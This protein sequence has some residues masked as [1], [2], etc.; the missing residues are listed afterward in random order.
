M[1]LT[2]CLAAAVASVI[3]VDAA[4]AQGCRFSPM[5][6]SM[7]EDCRDASIVFTAWVESN[8]RED[9]QNGCTTL[10]IDGSVR[11]PALL[12][13]P[14]RITIDRFIPIDAD[15]PPQAYLIFADVH[16]GKL[17]AFRGTPLKEPALTVDYLRGI[18][19]LDESN[20]QKRVEYVFKHLRSREP[21][22]MSDAFVE[23]EKL[24]AD[25]VIKSG[26]GLDR[27]EVRQHSK[28]RDLNGPQLSNIVLLLAGC[29]K[30]DDVPLLLDILAQTQGKSKAG[31]DRNPA[32][33][34]NLERPLIALTILAPETGF[35]QIRRIIDDQKEDFLRRYGA[36]RAVRH[37]YQHPVA[38]IDRKSVVNAIAA[39][40]EHEDMADLAVEDLRRFERWEFAARI[41]Q[42]PKQLDVPI[43]RRAVLRYALSASKEA[44]VAAEY[45]TLMRAL[46][47]EAVKDAEAAIRGDDD[48]P[49]K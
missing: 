44:K 23:L 36:L 20:V 32:A 12:G 46:N 15:K 17:D 29:G 27:T 22:V 16:K 33:S 6:R 24:E 7:R 31:V 5:P 37:L 48:P 49:K 41:V 40:L 28:R 26:R 13:L 21:E 35:T 38:K 19:A 39:F 18:L 10:R 25:E 2:V 30:A 14:E 45:V 8:R 11:F 4:N 47:P 42:L 43:V 34:M 9:D 3:F 1:R